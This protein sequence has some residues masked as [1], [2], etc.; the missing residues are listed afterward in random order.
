MLVAMPK[1][2]VHVLNERND[3]ASELRLPPSRNRSQSRNRSV[4]GYFAT[5]T[6]NLQVRVELG[7]PMGIPVL[8]PVTVTNP[9]PQEL[10]QDNPASD[11]PTADAPSRQ[12]LTYDDPAQ[13]EGV[14]GQ[15]R[16]G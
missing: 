12:V 7:I 13:Q 2:I 15:A 1:Y 3:G 9:S 5:I 6:D 8:D 10:A 14:R 16:Q 4:N 11:D